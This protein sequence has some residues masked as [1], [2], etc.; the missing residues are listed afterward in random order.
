MK[1]FKLSKDI[2]NNTAGLSCLENYLLYALIAE[3]YPY[4][5]LYYKSY[6][7]LPEI[8]ASFLHGNKYKSFYT[9]RR[10]QQIAADHN[11][12][13]VYRYDRRDPACFDFHDFNCIMV[14]PEYVQ[15]RYGISLLR[16][17]HYMLLCPTENAGEY[18]CI[19]DCPRDIGVIRLSEL[20]RISTGKM[21]CF[22]ILRPP[23]KEQNEA[24]LKD[25]YHSINLEKTAQ[26][27]FSQIDI[28]TA[29]DILGIYK[30][31]SRR[32]RDFCS[33]YMSM[34]FY[35]SHLEWIERQYMMLEYMR[36]LGE[37]DS[38]RIQPLLAQL[39]SESNQ[40]ISILKSKMEEIL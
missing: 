15:E 22:D 29:R 18:A 25:L 6:L 31:V 37:K 24:F 4:P 35:R 16:D 13:Q 33:L 1:Q 30:V 38:Y 5:Y 27:D 17:D 21:F 26:I 40:T 2:F 14:R 12:I 11:F 23:N 32:L 8:I 10:L 34:D 19:N 28:V 20:A 7:S 3:N 39:C 9:I 36:L